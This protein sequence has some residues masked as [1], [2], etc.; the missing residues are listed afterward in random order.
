MQKKITKLQAYNAMTKLLQIYFDNQPSSDLA[1]LLSGMSFLQ[2]HKTVDLAMWEIWGECLERILHEKNL[3]NFNYL[4][5]LEAFI[6]MGNFLEHILQYPEDERIKKI[7]DNAIL[8]R[9]NNKIDTVL[10]QN[11]LRCVDEVLT[12]K[13]SREYFYLLP[14]Q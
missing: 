10:W 9:D 5:F 8:A 11:W 1:M 13:D 14:K 6:V 7:E 4:T 3:R 2:N 12:V